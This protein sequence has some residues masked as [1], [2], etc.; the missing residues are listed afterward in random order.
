MA[1]ARTTLILWLILRPIYM[2][3]LVAVVHGGTISPV[4][5]NQLSAS[6][7]KSPHSLRF[8]TVCTSVSAIGVN[9]CS[10]TPGLV[11]QVLFL[12]TNGQMKIKMTSNMTKQLLVL[13][14]MTNPRLFPAGTV[15][16]ISVAAAV[17]AISEVVSEVVE[18]CTDVSASAVLV[19]TASIPVVL[20]MTVVSAAVL[21]LLPDGTGVEDPVATVETFDVDL[22][23]VRVVF[24]GPPPEVFVTNGGMVEV[25]LVTEGGLVAVVRAV[26]FT[27]AAAVSVVTTDD[28]VLPKV[29]DVT[30]VVV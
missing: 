9:S 27:A 30:V 22:T 29:S 5:E 13:A 24:K 10:A 6:C 8:S 18:E 4:G 12:Q 15:R 17:E 16:L 2:F 20:N 23:A 26:D 28:K 3:S 19:V 1:A 7:C 14:P 21:C 11:H 25:C